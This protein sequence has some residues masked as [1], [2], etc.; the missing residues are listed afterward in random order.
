[1]P[2]KK[3][4]N[5]R[6]ISPTEEQLL[7]SRENQS[8][9]FKEQQH[10]MLI[11]SKEKFKQLCLKFNTFDLPVPAKN[12]DNF[13]N[14]RR[15]FNSI[16]FDNLKKVCNELIKL[17]EEIQSKIEN[18]GD[19]NKFTIVFKALTTKLLTLISIINEY[20]VNAENKNT[21]KCDN[22]YRIMA[23][24]VQRLQYLL[25]HTFD[26]PENQQD[27][28]D[29]LKLLPK[30]ILY[31][32][33]NDYLNAKESWNLALTC[34]VFFGKA[35]LN[36]DMA[37]LAKRKRLQELNNSK[38]I[39]TK[40]SNFLI[41]DNKFY[42]WGYNRNGKLGLGYDSNREIPV[43]FDIKRLNLSITDQVK[44][45]VIN[46][47]SSFLLTEKG[48]CF[49]WGINRYGQLGLGD[50][51]NRNTPVEFDIKC[52]NLSRTDKV[53]QFVIN[54]D[55]SF[56][57]TEE[58][59][60][61]VWGYNR[62]G[63]LGLDDNLNRNTPIEF[64]LQRL[65]LSANDKVKQF[66]LDFSSFLLTEEGRC[67]VWGTNED[68][69]LGLGDKLDKNTPVEFDLKCLNL[70]R[71]DKVKQFVI[72]FGSSFL[73]T[74]E[75]RCFVWGKNTCGTL[76]L[77]DE[78]KRKNPVEFNFM[79]LRLSITDKVQQ[80]VINFGSSFLLTEEGRCFVWGFNEHGTLGLGDDLN[81]DTPV[82]FDFKHFNL[83][84]TDKVKEFVIETSFSYLLTEEGRCFVW[85]K[86][87]HGELGLGDFHN[88]NTPVEFDFKR[89]NLSRTDKIKQFVITTF[90]PYLLT[91]EGRCFVWGK[92]KHG[93][94]GLDD[95]HIRNIPGEV[96]YPG[97]KEKQLLLKSIIS[98]LT[99]LAL[100]ATDK[101]DYGK[102]CYS[103][104]IRKLMLESKR[105]NQLVYLPELYQSPW[106]NSKEL[107]ELLPYVWIHKPF[108]K[109]LYGRPAE[110]IELATIMNKLLDIYDYFNDKAPSSDLHTIQKD[111][112]ELLEI[113][114]SG[115]INSIDK[116][117]SYLQLSAASSLDF[118][119]IQKDFI[120]LSETLKSGK[121][122]SI[123]KLSSYLKQ[124]TSSRSIMNIVQFTL[125]SR[126][127]NVPHISTRYYDL[128]QML[129]S[130]VI[131]NPKLLPHLKS[132]ADIL[133]KGLSTASQEDK[134]AFSL[135]SFIRIDAEQINMTEMDIRENRYCMK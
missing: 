120:E 35:H 11:E 58:G 106:S 80:F 104:L 28:F 127:I 73:L 97:F 85:G 78:K 56:L 87:K 44:Q 125:F 41:T 51:H 134:V 50:F 112:V 86:N 70:T 64:D 75:G 133:L 116:L 12:T 103:I 130:E 109:E 118:Q 111:F 33:A 74:E 1:M 100:F 39:T 10:N 17:L 34:K 55:F 16:N 135:R 37:Y 77:E 129:L 63:Q 121:I 114:K 65:N 57:L 123:D 8:K 89:L 113:L 62:S 18:V 92:N 53:K 42:V 95:F 107:T 22:L 15:Y 61:F 52:L 79:R 117:S 27:T 45:F 96:F 48:R 54:D 83:S 90:T 4:D 108:I 31:K 68:G 119:T 115:E 84:K 13:A 29:N 36:I 69:Q 9:K 101:A 131:N 126:V 38:L 122:D 98:D 88:R 49:V 7:V 59:R 47:N 124:S 110:K 93:Q 128:K 66:V 30:D 14:P 76:G 81:R 26:S 40:N 21:A 60:Y 91:E 71:T 24:A 82:E 20:I 5:K 3:D 19:Y 105:I 2:L 6:K 67:F 94:L 99:Q 25:M 102:D 43:E 72:N 132:A 46:I 23:E 32:I